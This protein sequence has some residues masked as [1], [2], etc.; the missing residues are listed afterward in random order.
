MAKK[1]SKTASKKKKAQQKQSKEQLWFAIAAVV[2]AI[3]AFV[4]F[5]TGG[6][7]DANTAGLPAEIN[8]QTAKQMF[9]EGAYMLDV[10]NPDEWVNF[11]VD[12]STLVP[13]PELEARVNEVPRDQEIIV[14]CNSGNRSQV[15]RDI[16]LEAGF[17]NVTS[18][19]GG[20]QGWMGAGYD[21]V[22]GE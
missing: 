9:D 11:H 20:I 8:T 2:L 1:R 17:T 12:G 13:L 5:G 6:N 7:N 21:F 14:I 10:R 16:L 19:A 3:L 15:A 4:V 22:T 18:I